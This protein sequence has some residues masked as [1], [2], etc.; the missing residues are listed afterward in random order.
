[1][2][3]LAWRFH[4]VLYR[5][6][7]RARKTRMSKQTLS[8]KTKQ[9]DRQTDY[10]V[11][12]NDSC[13]QFNSGEVWTA[14]SPHCGLRSVGRFKTPGVRTCEKLQTETRIDCRFESIDLKPDIESRHL[15]SLCDNK[16]HVQTN[17]ESVQCLSK[18]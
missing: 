9:T 14:D 7:T 1:M 6:A 11:T 10:S 12:S 17:T 2:Q 16:I 13:N 4:C 3:S 18:K 8:D 15:V 5:T